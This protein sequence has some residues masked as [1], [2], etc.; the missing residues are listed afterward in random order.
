M[1]KRYHMAQNILEDARR[2]PENDAKM[3]EYRE[4]IQDFS[5]LRDRQS[6]GTLMLQS[7]VNKKVDSMTVTITMMI[8]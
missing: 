4:A 1:L 2:S 8:K 6:R 3:D 5:L 7:D